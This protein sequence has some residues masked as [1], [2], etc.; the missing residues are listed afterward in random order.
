ME[1]GHEGKRY[2]LTGGESLS[3][4]EIA[5]IFSKELGRKITYTEISQAQ[6]AEAMAAAGTPPWLVEV[7]GELNVIGAKGYLA[8]V[9]ADTENLLKRK[10]ISF[11]QFVRENIDAFTS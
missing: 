8:A 6:A 9:A 7:L 5:E 3:E 10:P 1:T 4:A 2:D 11:S